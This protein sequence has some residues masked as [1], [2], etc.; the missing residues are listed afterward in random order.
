MKRL[1]QFSLDHPLLVNLFSLFVFVAGTIALFRLHREAFPNVSYDRVIITTIY[2]GADP[3]SIEKL[4]TIPLERE[5]KE[6]SDIKEM[7]SISLEGRSIL[8]LELEATVRNKDRTINEIQRAVDSTEDLPEDLEDLPHVKEVRSKDSPIIEVSLSGDMSEKELVEH[9]RRLEKKFLDIKQVSGVSRTGWREKEIWVEVRPETLTDYYLSLSELVAA[10]GAHNVNVPGGVIKER[11]GEFLIRTS[12]EFFG[13]KDVEKVIVRSNDS[14]HWVQVQDVATVTETFE[15]ETTLH[16]TNGKRAINLTVLK[17]EHADAILLTDE[18]KKITQ[19]YRE[20]HPDLGIAL[21]NDFSFYIKRRL[22]V[23]YQNGTIGFFLIVLCLVFFLPK[24]V[25]FMTAL[26]VPFALMATFF[27]M[28]LSGMTLNLITMFGLIT[29]LGMLVDD[30]IVVSENVCRYREEG[31]P[32]REAALLGTVEVWKPVT[33]SVLTTICAFLPLMFMSGVMGKF[34]FYIPL[35]VIVAL[36]ASLSEAFLVLPSHLAEWTKRS[37][38]KNHQIEKRFLKVAEKYVEWMVFFIRHRYRVALGFLAFFVFGIWLYFQIPFSLFPSRGVET[39]FVRAE[40]PVGTPLEE[41]AERF[42]Q[43]EKWIA[44]L[45]KEEVE[46]YVL[47]VGIQQNDP[48]DPFTE[49]FS[50]LGQIQVF[51]TPPADRDRTAEEIVQS[52]R[53]KGSDIQG[54]SH[55]E[56][57]MM[58]AG[59]PMG[60]P[61]AIRVRGEN[62]EEVR[63]VS[64]QILEGL[65]KIEGVKDAKL[66]EARGKKELLLQIDP[67]RTAQAG[68]S[69]KEVGLALRASFE[70]IVATTIKKTD[71]EIDIRVRFPKQAQEDRKNL[72]AVLIPNKQGKL[73]ALS[74][75][76]LF[77]E[78]ESVSA[79]RHHNR[80]RTISVLANVDEDQI[81]VVDVYDRFESKFHEILSQHPDLSLQFG[82]EF[83]ETQ[84]SLQGL[85]QAF[86]LGALLIFI[87]LA[88][89]FNS[90]WQPFVVMTSI[91]LGL[92]GVLLAFWIHGEPKSFLGLMGMVGLAGVVVNNAIVL[93]DFINEGRRQGMKK[94]ESI[95]QA[96]RLRFRPVLLTS[97][98]TIFGLVSLA[99][100]F[101]GSDP[102]LR[103]MALAFVWGILFSTILTLVA[104][105][106]FHAIADDWIENVRNRWLRWSR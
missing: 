47:R 74:Q 29:V 71:E 2:P 91:P 89:Q 5:L 11:E 57:S 1:I 40:A 3:L 52:L 38:A 97:I 78:E 54:L 45:P 73:I 58:K 104:I 55:L 84:E 32:L 49:R 41:T 18:V 101:W 6:V 70:G 25:A 59:P 15:E 63:Q 46:D 24:R 42:R 103:P 92:I 33:N 21:V 83:E 27:V 51:L 28:Q 61:I 56:F 37:S 69:L 93:V 76:A 20:Q 68:L 17:K 80:E 96:G 16:R 10:L 23:L 95:I 90:L 82:G 12:G 75:I 35:M 13:G 85:K 48:H 87:L 26:G 106:C 62:L 34:V 88:V 79:L 64:Q 8:I 67:V 72:E 36:L 105:P 94:L 14:R 77:K 31:M 39:F 81:T 66:D 60:Q 98:T 100:G 19:T 30:A 7:N 9:A 43:L 53:K 65:Q 86:V 22:N 4:I 50:H 44:T 99:Y 102:F